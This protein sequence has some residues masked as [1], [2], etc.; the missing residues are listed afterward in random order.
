MNICPLGYSCSIFAIIVYSG[1]LLWP[2][3]SPSGARSTVSPAMNQSSSVTLWLC[4]VYSWLLKTTR[5]FIPAK[6][7]KNLNEFKWNWMQ[8]NTTT[9]IINNTR[10][11]KYIINNI[12]TITRIIKVLKIYFEGYCISQTGFRTKRIKMK[13]FFEK[14][15][16]STSKS[17]LLK[18]L[19]YWLAHAVATP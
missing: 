10:I 12:T 8:N 3:L 14:N 4:D 15:Q 13:R 6:K 7:E 11:N 2:N 5:V 1:G 17:K 18:S 9:S 19:I 16:L